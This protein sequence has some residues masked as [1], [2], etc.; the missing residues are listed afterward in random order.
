MNN[1]EWSFFAAVKALHG[2]LMYQPGAN[3]KKHFM[4]NLFV[5]LVVSIYSLYLYFC[6]KTAHKILMKFVSAFKDYL[7]SAL[8]EMYNDKIQHVQVWIVVEEGWMFPFQQQN[9]LADLDS[10]LSF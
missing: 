1:H 8:Q 10:A 4:R 2:I 3:F 9:G 7:Y 5:K 6:E